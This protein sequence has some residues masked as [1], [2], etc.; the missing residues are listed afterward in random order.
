MS[1]STELTELPECPQDMAAILLKVKE[2]E[3]KREK[4]GARKEGERRTRKTERRKKRRRRTKR[5]GGGREKAQDES[6]LDFYHLIS[7]ETH[8]HFCHMLGVTHTNPVWLDTG[9]RG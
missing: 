7:E 4:G 5:R 8:P 6:Y 2:K 9:E 1:L 3:G